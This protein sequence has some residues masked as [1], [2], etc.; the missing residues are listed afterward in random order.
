M[1]SL[2]RSVYG[3]A[4]SVIPIQ[5]SA[6]DGGGLVALVNARVNISVVAGLV[7]PPMFE[8]TQ[9]YFTV[10]EDAMRGTVVG[11]VQASSKT[12]GVYKHMPSL[13]CHSLARSPTHSQTLNHT[14]LS[15]TVHIELVN[16]HL[17]VTLDHTKRSFI[18]APCTTCT[19][20]RW[21]TIYT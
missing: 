19:N 17:S 18:S 21:A 2:S 12:G 6:Q 14:I 15:P 20:R 10:S 3:K 4:N 7:A 13:L 16:I 1:I 9:Y 5:I 8:Q 11:I